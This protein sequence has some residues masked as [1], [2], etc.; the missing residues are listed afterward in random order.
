MY[1]AAERFGRYAFDECN[2]MRRD[3]EFYVL[4]TDNDESTP[5]Y[6]FVIAVEVVTHFLARKLEAL[7]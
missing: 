4:V 1:E 3:G 7:K 2:M 5:V 6:H